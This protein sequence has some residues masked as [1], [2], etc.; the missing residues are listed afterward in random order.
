MGANA[1]YARGARA[2]VVVVLL[3]LASA[4]LITL[5]AA[6]PVS[7]ANG[8]TAAGVGAVYTLT[9]AASGNAV[10]WYSR[11]V[12]GHLT[13]R[14]TVPAGG[15]GTGGGLG[16]QGALVLGEDDSVLLAVDA[17]SNQLS[18]FAVTP[19]GLVLTGVVSSGGMMPVSVTISGNLVYVVNAGGAP[20]IAGFLLGSDGSLTMIPG[21][22]QTL[23]GSA[24]AEIAFDPAGNVLVVTEKATS[25]IDTF[26]V[27]ANGVASAAIPHVSNGAT[28][29][30]FAFDN[31]GRLLVS[32]VGGGPSG[33][34]AL[35]S[36]AVGP[37][38]SLTTISASVPDFEFAAC[39]VVTTSNG[40]FAYTSNAHPPSN[41]LST[42]AVG[43]SGQLSLSDQV[44]AQP[45]TGPTD[46]SLSRNSKFL[47]V[48]DSGEGA[49]AGFA[50]HVDGS[51]SPI[52]TVSG[53]LSSDV[54]LAAT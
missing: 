25:T 40:Q 42:Y 7:A 21:S 34:S 51:L 19:G 35:S 50:I 20:N 12:T 13:W 17:G 3:V 14:A 44:A 33:T 5:V 1:T 49:I 28:P 23:T 54:G 18:G 6:N 11:S 26:T 2:F 27:D 47:Y 43:G 15:L 48:L 41:D 30:G 38:G 52:S 39:W 22:S 46:L 45:G 16:S 4:L 29:F 32:E 37:D 8:P 36:Y 31:K 10:V 53:L 9:N 24:P